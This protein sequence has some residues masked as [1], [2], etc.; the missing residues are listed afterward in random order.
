MSYRRSIAVCLCVALLAAPGG[1]LAASETRLAIARDWGRVTGYVLDGATGEPVAGARVVVEEG[2]AFADRGPTT[3]QTNA[4]GRYQV[5]ARIGRKSS[6]LDVMSLVE[7][8]PIGL[9]MPWGLFKQTRVVDA[10]QCLMQVDAPGYKPF[11]GIVTAQVASATRFS[12]HSVDILLAREGTPEASS[13]PP[14]R[15]RERLL[16]FT[17]EPRIAAPGE[18]VTFTARFRLPDD[19]VRYSSGCYTPNRIFRVDEFEMRPVG[20]PDSETGTRTFQATL[21]V[22]K[23]PREEWAVFRLWLDRDGRY[24]EVEL[25]RRRDLLL[26]IAQTPE[27]RAAAQLASHAF[28][29]EQAGRLAD[30]LQHY[31]RAAEALP[32]RASLWARIG[33]LSLRLNRPAESIAAFEKLIAADPNHP[34]TTT[35]HYAMAL[36]AAGET[37]RA[38][39]ALSEVEK[40][41]AR[42]GQLPR[43]FLLA[44]ARA[45]L[46][47]S[48]LQ[49]ADRYYARAVKS[50]RVPNEVAQQF[51]LKRARAAVKEM[52][53][54]PDARAG[55]ARALF[56]LGRYEEA[57]AA[58]RQALR[59]GPAQAWG[60]LDLAICLTAAG[61]DRDAL[62]HYRL[63]VELAPENLEACL[64]LAECHR[65]LGEFSPALEAYRKVAAAPARRYDYRVQHGLALALLATGQEAS[66]ME[67]LARAVTLGRSKGR[68]LGTRLPTGVG[69][70]SLTPKRVAIDAFEH[71]EMALDYA[72]L[73][74]LRV[75]RQAPDSSPALF[76]AGAALI[77]L[78]VAEKGLEMLERALEHGFAPPDAQYA[79]AMACLRLERRAE[80][81][82]LLERLTRENPG[83]RRAWLAL[84]RIHFDAGNSPAGKACLLRAQAEQVENR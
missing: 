43:E 6:H 12:L 4:E 66:A 35:S 41:S 56:D 84:A 48:D 63:A 38:L 70:L 47:R 71:P 58:Y 77:E 39:D 36:L 22:P 5:R 53:E 44:M 61:K 3:G 65:R 14:N 40:K 18:K 74:S 75:L 54:N 16:A 67:A 76:Q 9:L 28:D 17:L 45:H 7:G 15:T 33:H 64:A 13:A 49:T 57:A 46:A 20:K 34:E 24:Q 81:R 31:R 82:E 37:Q 83:H 50:G 27:E 69:T 30:A 59:L 26:Q 62:P 19:G 10:R 51:H 55:L 23:R 25:P 78:G 79:R 8:F 52:P 32:E 72:L 11:L 68:L 80:A 42:R 60:H 1:A 73:N 21:E 29:L 2:G